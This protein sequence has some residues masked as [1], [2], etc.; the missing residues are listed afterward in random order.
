MGVNTSDCLIHPT[1]FPDVSLFYQSE[2]EC[3]A[4]QRTFWSLCQNQAHGS[5]KHAF[6]IWLTNAYPTDGMH[7]D[8]AERSS[9]VFAHICR[10]NHS[11]CPNL[12]GWH[13]RLSG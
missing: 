3:E 9:A 12:H 4:V 10:L 6:G 8:A 11:C 7:A 5:V 2:P 1:M 13:V